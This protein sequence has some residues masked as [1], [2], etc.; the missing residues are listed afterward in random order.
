[1][2]KIRSFY[3]LDEQSVC[4]EYVEGHRKVLEDYGILNVTSY[5]KDWIRHAY[6]HGVVAELDGHL[7]GGI[8]VQIA[9]GQTP[10]PVETAVG[11]MDPGVYAL[12]VKHLLDG[13]TGELCGLW[14]AKEV[15]GKGV[16]LLLVRAAISI[17]NQLRFR[18]LLGIC[19]EYSLPMF[20]RVGFVIDRTLG[21]NGDFIYPTEEYLAKVVGIMNAETLATSSDYDR[22][23]MLELRAHPRTI[24]MENGPKGEFEVEY[25]LLVPFVKEVLLTESLPLTKTVVHL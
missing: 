12:V 18:T 4:L 20:T 2:L 15:A 7:V 14:N 3:P 22:M 16:S 24:V 13:G 5:N 21:N 23:R 19:A 25:D 11:K 10:L 17:I 8:R 1:M 6:T 9:D